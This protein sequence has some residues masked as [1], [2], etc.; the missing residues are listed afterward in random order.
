MSPDIA[1]CPLEVGGKIISIR[2]PVDSLTQESDI[3]DL[4]RLHKIKGQVNGE[5]NVEKKG[6]LYTYVLRVVIPAQCGGRRG[7]LLA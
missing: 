1:K 5:D 7:R 3:R 4:T 2:E 6:L